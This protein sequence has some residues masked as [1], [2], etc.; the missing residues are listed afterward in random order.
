MLQGQLEEQGK[1]K[2]ARKDKQKQDDAEYA[3]KMQEVR[4]R[5]EEIR[6]QIESEKK[7]IFMDEIENQKRDKERFNEIEANLKKAED[8]NYRKKLEHDRQVLL[9]NMERKKMQMQEYLGK[10]GD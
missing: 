8:E 2:S 7:K 1:D 9:D 3:R 6:I 4:M 5:D 10:L